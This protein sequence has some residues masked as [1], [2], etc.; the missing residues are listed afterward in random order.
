MEKEFSFK[1]ERWVKYDKEGLVFNYPSNIDVDITVH[2][3]KIILIEIKS[4]V[5]KSDFYGKVE[6]KR[7]LR[8]TM[9][10][11]YAE[12]EAFEAASHLNIEIYTKV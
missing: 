12:K 3:E 8:L 11:P 1:V 10:T 6:G 5:R 4:H 2:N 7:P 9:V